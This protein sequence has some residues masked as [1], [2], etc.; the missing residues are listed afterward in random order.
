M[1]AVGGPVYPLPMRRFRSP[2]PVGNLA[3]LALLAAITLEVPL[4][5]WACSCALTTPADAFENADAIYVGEVRSV[6]GIR[7]CA[8]VKIEVTE[9]FKGAE[10]GEVITRGV[11][12]GFG[13]GDCSI[14]MPFHKGESW[15]FYGRD[16][17]ISSCSGH[18]LASEAEADIEQLRELASGG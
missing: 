17:D 12:V 16:G 1:Q 9:P 7:G 11:H 8:S 15:L 14:P 3:G 5:A 13:G 4:P 10:V 18:E 6:G 2:P